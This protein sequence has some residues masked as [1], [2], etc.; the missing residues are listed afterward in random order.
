MYKTESVPDLYVLLFVI[1]GCALAGPPGRQDVRER[2][3][4][5]GEAAVGQPFCRKAGPNVR[6]G[7]AL[8][9]LL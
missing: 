4:F 1:L 6:T 5:V 9:V 2:R 3:A 7:I 8:Q